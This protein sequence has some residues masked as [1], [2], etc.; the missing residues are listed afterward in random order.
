MLQTASTSDELFSVLKDLMTV[1]SLESFRLVGGTAL[2]LQLGHRISEDIDLFASE[3]YGSINFP[4]LFEDLKP[5]FS[6]VGDD[7]AILGLQNIENNSGLHLHIG[8][9]KEESIKTDILNWT[10]SAWLD[11]VKEIE[12]IR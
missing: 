6:Y 11:P 2:S 1:P 10:I 3:P 9:S 8:S 4:K 7:D 5:L 12:G